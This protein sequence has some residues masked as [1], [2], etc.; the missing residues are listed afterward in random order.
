MAKLLFLQN[1]EYEFL[2]PAYLSAML[3]K[4]GHQV[5]MSF[6]YSLKEFNPTI[7]KFK[8]DLVAFSIMSG[9][10]KWSLEMAASVKKA[11]GIK[12]IFGGP[13]PTHFPDFIN[14]ENVDIIAR[15]EGEWASLELMNCIDARIDYS[16]V[17]NLWVK[18]DGIIYRNE[19]RCLDNDLDIYPFADRDLYADFRGK[20][21][22]DIRQLI[23][24]R[25]CPWH[26][27]FC[28][29][30]SLREL[31]KD[32]GRYVRIR[33]VDTVVEEARRLKSDYRAR[34]IYFADDVF[35]LDRKWLLDFLPKYKKN[36]GLPFICL[37]RA[38]ILA[39]NED[40]AM[41]LAKH[42]CIMLSFGIESGN[43]N[44]RNRV[45]EKNVK[46][47]DIYKAAKLLHQAGIKFRTFNILGLPGETLQDALK[48]VQVNIDIKTD[49]PWC[50]IFMPFSGTRLTEYA[51]E[52]NYLSSSD[53]QKSFFSGSTLINH[54]E[55]KRLENLQS[56][57]QTAVIFPKSLK[58]IKLL[59]KLPPNLLFK[60]WF[61]FVYFFVYIKAERRGFWKTLIF[62]L[63]NYRSLLD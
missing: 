4:H 54:P 29:N 12:N 47:S 14:E 23:T 6:G 1:L 20:A 48:T 28:F 34:I 49:F 3:K 15:G 25:G 36:V 44:T 2:G 24:S 61:G 58:A 18:K 57:F 55:I 32:K 62:S 37:I 46:D 53:S 51:K 59:I 5:K 21:D 31:Y 30:D 38:D 63:K 19:L 10:Y 42:G 43:E 41:L 13:H 8:P 7:S 60:L 40:Y 17:K 45:L 56:F 39:K 33:A 52:N 16:Q 9:S 11:F 26:C 27:S 50:S 22:L 35:G